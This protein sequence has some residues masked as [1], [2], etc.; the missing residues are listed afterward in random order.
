MTFSQS[1]SSLTA[2]F[3]SPGAPLSP[4]RLLLIPACLPFLALGIGVGALL[5]PTPLFAVGTCSTY[6][7]GTQ[8]GTL[9][10]TRLD[11]ASGLAASQQNSGIYWTH[12]DSGNTAALFAIGEEGGIVAEFSVSNA[13]NI[14]WEDINIGPCPSGCACLFIAD[15]GDN[16]FIRGRKTIYRVPEPVLGRD[17]DQTEDAEA[18]EF[19]YPNDLKYDAET[20]LVDPR[21]GDLYIVTKETEATS[22]HIYKYPVGAPS[23][24]TLELVG[25]VSLEGGSS[26]FATSGSVSADGGRLVIRT[27]S[28]ALEFVIPEGQPL[29]AAFAGAPKVIPL[30]SSSQGEAISYA[31]DGMSLL[32][33]SENLPA[34]VSQVLCS[35]GQPIT[36]PVP[37]LTEECEPVS[38]CRVA[39]HGTFPVSG[40][41]LGPLSLLLATLFR[42]K[43]HYTRAR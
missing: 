28:H 21:S 42:R 23:P 27:L 36:E 11:E 5:S 7:T 9:S 37:A 40:G 26:R 10:D 32:T 22:S 30:P 1:S 20:L 14:D 6:A 15:T 31:S 33:V 39:P 2:C 18:L 13:N 8:V 19:M 43:T 41:V 16:L 3:V 17:V 35:V 38:G 34:P 29:E 25:Q 4:R 12:N 24:A